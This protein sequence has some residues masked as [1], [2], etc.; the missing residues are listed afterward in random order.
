MVG[1]KKEG[2]LISSVKFQ[3]ISYAM[4]GVSTW[5]PK[6]RPKNKLRLNMKKLLNPKLAKEKI[7]VIDSEDSSSQENLKEDEDLSKQVEN[8]RED[9]VIE[10]PSLMKNTVKEQF[11]D[12]SFMGDNS[13]Q[14]P[15][16]VTEQ[17]KE[18]D[19]EILRN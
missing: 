9:S 16:T 12:F 1:F 2:V 17:H 11:K 3:G 15:V 13:N 19:E 4:L 14:V 8:K 6:T 18:D 7:T 5:R 10:N